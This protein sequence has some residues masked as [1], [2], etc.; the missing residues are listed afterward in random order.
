MCLFKFDISLAKALQ[1]HADTD[2]SRWKSKMQT[3][4][5]GSLFS[6]V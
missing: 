5:T 4:E 1:L 6:V 2:S 3:A